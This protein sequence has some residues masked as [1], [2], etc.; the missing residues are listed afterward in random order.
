MI[1][2]SVFAE[3]SDK[4][5]QSGSS[6]DGFWQ[7]FRAAVAAKDGEAVANL[8]EFPIEMSYGIATIENK[9]Q[10]LSRF[11][12][13]FHEQTDAGNCFGKARPE[14]D[15]ENPNLFTVACPDAAGNEVVIY[16]F[17]KTDSGWKFSGLDNINE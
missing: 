13:V 9:T 17:G 14:M 12:E 16:H 3:P 6:I 4:P 5:P 11:H 15:G 2:V 1:T 7:R 8:S 10:L